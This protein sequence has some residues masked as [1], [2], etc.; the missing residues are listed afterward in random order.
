MMAVSP[1]RRV[2]TAPAPYRRG[3]RRGSSAHP[4][5]GSGHATQAQG[6]GECRGL[7]V[8]MWDGGP[9]SLAAGYSAPDARHPGRGTGLIDEDQAVRVKVRLSVEPGPTPLGDVGRLQ[10]GCAS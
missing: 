2:G 10:L 5:P 1:R 4:G 7:A 9:A 3:A 8:T 6:A